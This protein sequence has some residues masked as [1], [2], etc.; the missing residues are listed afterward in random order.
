M[1][2]LSTFIASL[3]TG[4]QDT[5]PDCLVDA[6]EII[7]ALRCITARGRALD[8]TVENGVGNHVGRLLE[9]L[10]AGDYSAENLQ[11]V[12][13]ALAFLHALTLRAAHTLD[14][15]LLP[16]EL[17]MVAVSQD[18]LI[19]LSRTATAMPAG[20]S[21]EGV[22][23]VDWA[24]LPLF[25]DPVPLNVPTISAFI[26]RRLR[27]LM[28]PPREDRF[29]C[30]TGLEFIDE[31]D[32]EEGSVADELDGFDDILDLWDDIEGHDADNE[33]EGD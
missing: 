29:S 8:S 7:D 11:R 13:V 25:H 2:P 16:E 22:A 6:H 33:S 5:A 30:G 14:Q 9:S 27:G 3:L 12:V 26:R 18:G 23:S 10:V 15:T 31:S 28:F 32:I 4:A 19:A 1:E 24:S 17:L 21:P 20:L